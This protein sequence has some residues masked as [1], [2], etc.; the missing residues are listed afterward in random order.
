M[1]CVG[2]LSEQQKG[3]GR[4][5]SKVGLV[6]KPGNGIARWSLHVQQQHTSQTQEPEVHH[7][8]GTDG[9]HALFEAWGH[10]WLSAL[11]FYRPLA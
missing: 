8:G 3:Q 6:E 2:G 10:T 9:F 5:L 7:E 1:S 11:G 4:R